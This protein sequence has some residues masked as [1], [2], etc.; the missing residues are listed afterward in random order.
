[1]SFENSPNLN[2]FKEGLPEKLSDPAPGK[3]RIRITLVILFFA[4]V[5]LSVA[6]F[7]QSQSAT[8]LLGNGAVQGIAVNETGQPFAGGEVFIVGVEKIVQTSADG[9]FLLK[10]IPAGNRELVVADANTGRV[11]PIQVIA[12][13]T[14]NI[15]Q[16]QFIPTAMP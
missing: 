8:L 9:S 10:N 13:Q 12:G 14:I 3:K 15:G 11:Y 2:N 4:A 7:M 5:L 6:N 1:M 16:V